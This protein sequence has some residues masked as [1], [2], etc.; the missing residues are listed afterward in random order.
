MLRLYG[1]I[2]RWLPDSAGGASRREMV[3]LAR[4]MRRD[5]GGGPGFHV[6]L[7]WDAVSQVASAWVDRMTK[8]TT[9][10]T[11]RRVEETMTT[12]FTDLKY[13]LRRIVRQP[14]F[15]AMIVGLVAVGIAGNTAVFRV[16]NGLFLR[17]LPFDDG[18]RLVDLD[19]TAP[20]WN[21]EFVNVSIGDF[22]LWKEG[23]STFE[24][25]AVFSQRGANL[26]ADGGATR[27]NALAA[28][29]DLT[30]VLRLTPVRGRFF[31]AE[32]DRPD[33]ALVALLTHGFWTARFGADPDVVGSTIRLAGRSAEVIGVLP[34]TADALADVDVW[35]PLQEDDVSS[36]YLN[37]VGRL[38]DGVTVEQARDDLETVHRSVIAERSVNE[39]TTPTVLGLRERYLGPQRLGAG[40]LMGAVGLVLLLACG[41]IAGLM[42]ARSISRRDEMA[43]RRALGAPRGRLVAEV[44]TESLLLAG[45]GAVVGTVL[46]VQG[47]SRM[48][49]GL[50]D[51]FPAWVS[52]D[53]DGTFLAFSVAL[54][55]G[56]AV[57]FGLAPALRSARVADTTRSG[58]GRTTASRRTRRVM[59]GLVAAEVAGAAVLLVGAGLAL[60]DARALGRVDPGFDAAGMVTWRMQLDGAR[61]PEAD[62][63]LDFMDRYEARLAAVPGVDA[64]ALAS[65]LPLMGHSGWFFQVQGHERPEGE[66]G[67]VVLRRWVS[68]DYLASMG[69]EMER[70]RA[71]EA[72][73]GRGGGEGVVVVNETFVRTHI[74]EGLDPLGLRIHTGGDDPE[75][76]TIVGVA[77]DVRHYGPDVEMR[78]ATYEPLA[79][80]PPSILQGAVRVGRGDPLAVVAELRAATGEIDPSVPLF[81]VQTMDARLDTALTGRRAT[82]GV[83]AAFA[84]VALILAVA[85]LYGVISYTVGQR[86]SEISVRMAMGAA[87]GAVSRQVVREGM[88][89]VGVG[90]FVGLLAARA[91]AGPISGLLVGVGA[92]DPWV[93]GGVALL[94]ATVAAA[95]NWIPARR[96]ARTDPMRALRG[97]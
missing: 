10:T 61:Y 25:M 40:F 74:P 83:I 5:G 31:T 75:L 52:F 12:R 77:R 88:V 73:D 32:E 79:Q 86:T 62:Q 8:T 71:F 27:I 46:G 15:S 13:A 85:G 7:V 57:L 49:A 66:M 29:Y 92:A 20:E 21:L 44:F 2:L 35:I 96:A 72:A 76:H 93:Y 60:R 84:A 23:N 95:A 30:E 81:D 87:G 50:G 56:A 78:P 4:A 55:A 64:V 39:I 67:P 22:R 54:T 53:V 6:R 48:V 17:P 89:L 63:R 43:V 70:G 37:G 69:V 26:E 11:T 47:S 42:M 97:E 65:N 38:R 51:Q 94:L 36:F 41:N 24:S 59:G 9:K 16:A 19:E 45:T 18:A 58:A 80:G 34:E 28:T 1:W 33:E 91:A 3:E 68:P 82:T 90:L 14:L